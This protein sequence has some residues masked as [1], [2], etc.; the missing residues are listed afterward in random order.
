MEAIAVTLIE[1][2]FHLIV[3]EPAADA[4]RTMPGLVAPVL[5]ERY[6]TIS[7]LLIITI[8]HLQDGRIVPFD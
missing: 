1:P 7:P 4:S 2:S 3:I 5:G 8:N 6:T